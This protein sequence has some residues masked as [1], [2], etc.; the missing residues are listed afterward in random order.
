MENIVSSGRR[1]R[2]VQ[3]VV[4]ALVAAATTLWLIRKEAMAFWFGLVFVLVLLAALMFVQAR[5]KT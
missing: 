1:R 3:G 5:D 4:I 2:L